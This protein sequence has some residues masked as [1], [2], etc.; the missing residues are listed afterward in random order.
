MTESELNYWIRNMDEWSSIADG[1]VKI[2]NDLNR[3]IIPAFFLGVLV[4]VLW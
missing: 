3:R 4:G 2:I 1:Y